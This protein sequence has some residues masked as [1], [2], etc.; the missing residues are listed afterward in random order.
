M[1]KPCGGYSLDA[2]AKVERG[3]TRE[4]GCDGHYALVGDGLIA[5]ELQSFELIEH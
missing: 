5:P 3:E 4:R 1:D 2:R